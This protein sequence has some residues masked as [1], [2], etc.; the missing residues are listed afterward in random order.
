MDCVS[1]TT[2][3]FSFTVEPCLGE[4]ANSRRFRW[5]MTDSV[6]RKAI[7]AMTYS[8]MREAMKEGE[9]A[10]KRAIK[11]GYLPPHGFL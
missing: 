10:T 8:T 2:V 6:G 7:G 9:A 11:S 5:I 1:A 3:A 4:G